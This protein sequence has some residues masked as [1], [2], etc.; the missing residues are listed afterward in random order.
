MNHAPSEKYIFIDEASGQYV[1]VV[2]NDQTNVNYLYDKEA[3]DE[4]ALL[5]Y[6]GYSTMFNSDMLY[7]ILYSGSFNPFTRTY[8]S[9]NY[10]SEGYDISYASIQFLESGEVSFN[11]NMSKTSSDVITHYVISGIIS[12]INNTE[13]E[14]PSYS[15]IECNHSLYIE[16]VDDWYDD[17]C[18]LY[19][20]NCH[21]KL[22]TEHEGHLYLNGEEVCCLC[23]IVNAVEYVNDYE[24]YN[25]FFTRK[26]S[27]ANTASGKCYYHESVLYNEYYPCSRATTHYDN[28]EYVAYYYPDLNVIIFNEVS[29]CAMSEYDSC[30]T[31]K[32]TTVIII[33]NVVLEEGDDHWVSSLYDEVFPE[34]GFMYLST[35]SPMDTISNKYPSAVANNSKVFYSAEAHKYD[36]TDKEV[37]VDP[38]TSEQYD[39]YTCHICGM[40]YNWHPH[41][42]Y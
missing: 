12:N 33:D 29:R 32:K 1:K 21:K 28:K 7:G 24:A 5:A 37:M 9:K 38:V 6:E 23:G 14:L 16:R 22:S 17:Y 36:E 26:H 3:E 41:F 10:Y 2:E 13:F 42:D 30:V 27:F 31:Y 25:N 40:R 11:I 8:T 4:I 20:S 35:V 39:L 19:C 18:Y 34:Y 15:T